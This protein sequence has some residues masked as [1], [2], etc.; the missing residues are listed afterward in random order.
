MRA[1]PAGEVL[2]ELTIA[3]RKV[4]HDELLPSP[5]NDQDGPTLATHVDDQAV[6]DDTELEHDAFAAG[7]EAGRREAEAIAQ[8]RLE[9]EIALREQAVAQ[10]RAAWCRDEAQA[11]GQTVATALERL[12]NA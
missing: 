3:T 1:I 10:A 4:V 11:L 9:E 7:Y 6:P 2:T 12:A 8:T 5:M